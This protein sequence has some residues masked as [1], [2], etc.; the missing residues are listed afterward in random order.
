MEQIQHDLELLSR[1][2]ICTAR[3]SLFC[4]NMTSEIAACGISACAVVIFS[5]KKKIWRKHWW[6]RKALADGP[7]FWLSLLEKL[8]LEDN[9]GF[10]KMNTDVFSNYHIIH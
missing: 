2:H 9:V 7:T 8:E 3:F 10:K 4:D 1:V 5:N 6:T